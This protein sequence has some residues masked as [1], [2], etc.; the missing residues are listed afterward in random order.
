MHNSLVV[1][2]AMGRSRIW[3]G[4]W[5]SIGMSCIA[6]GRNKV[7]QKKGRKPPLHARLVLVDVSAQNV[8]NATHI[9]V[10]MFH[11]TR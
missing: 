6:I 10:F 2:K 5:I 3:S 11:Y 9:E 4:A 7:V 1:E 8:G